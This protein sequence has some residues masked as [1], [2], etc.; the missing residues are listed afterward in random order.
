[1]DDETILALATG[2]KC[3]LGK[4][5][6]TLEDNLNS[7]SVAQHT[8]IRGPRGMGKSFF[9]KYLQ[10]QFKK[11]KIFKNCEFLLLPE[12]QNNINTTSDLIKLILS[13]LTQQ[14]GVDATTFWEEPD[15]VW[16]I[17]LQKLKKYIKEKTAK[18]KDYMLVVVVENLHDFL[19]NIEADKKTAKVHESRFRH[20][21][22]KI[23]NLTIIGAVPRIDSDI[24]DGNYNKRLFHAFK[25]CTLK[26]WTTEDYFKYFDR[27][28][29]LSNIQM[30]QAE[31][32]LKRAKLKALSHFTG[33]S[34]RM[35]VV[36]TNLLLEDNV[37]STANTLFGLIDDLTPYYQDLTKSIPRQSKKLFDTLIRKGE[38]CSQS[39][40]AEALGTAQNKISKA[41]LWLRDNGYVIGKKRSDSPAFSYQ[42][43]DRIHVL[44]YQ[45]R[46]IHHN[47]QITPIWLLSDFLVAF[48]QSDEL[49]THAFK[50]LLEQPSANANDLARL[51]LIS[52]G[53]FEKGNLPEFETSDE[54][55]GLIEKNH[56]ID[57]LLSEIK[58][59]SDSKISKPLYEKFKI[60]VEEVI[61]VI[62]RIKDE[63]ILSTYITKIAC[64][65]DRFIKEKN[66][67]Y[68]EFLFRE[69]LPICSGVKSDLFHGVI[70]MRIGLMSFCDYQLS[71]KYLCKAI[72]FFQK[73]NNENS[74]E[75]SVVKS[76]L[77]ELE[78][79]EKIS[80]LLN[81]YY[82]SE[83]NRNAPI[84][85]YNG[86]SFLEKKLTYSECVRY[87]ITSITLAD[88][89][90]ELNYLT[91]S[92]LKSKVSTKLIMNICKHVLDKNPEP[93]V[94]T[95]LQTT[96]NTI[97]YLESNKSL[98]YLEKLPPD[99]AIAIKAIV[100]EAKL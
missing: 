67:L 76:F 95:Y 55:I 75:L 53:F 37:I 29:A 87:G 78:R 6:K 2:R 32:S 86:L 11:K 31:E 27:R 97:H 77:E 79:S 98:A 50:A 62:T 26:K 92:W 99:T 38:N 73:S 71:K 72:T 56:E 15:E 47:Q 1:M 12:E 63:K 91:V 64:V 10:I 18:N 80:A 14:S 58:T 93:K 33:G 22:E 41:F 17:E 83:Q 81:E 24:I 88:Y 94:K 74:Y 59:Y 28:V 4:V 57:T 100:E 40:L 8:L 25:K 5:M 70:S 34:P 52:S 54:W 49:R 39:E 42:V 82:K 35:A 19:T 96:V 69:L 3:L 68:A 9:L 48:Y 30:T 89:N 84:N 60:K 90:S 23:K 66:F 21:L 20:L 7:E 16:Q 61:N 65:G 51:Y 36:L 44:Y 45:L 85:F 13:E 43:A 46:E